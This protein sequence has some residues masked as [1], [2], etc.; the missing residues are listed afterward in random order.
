MISTVV[1]F[2]A[3]AKTRSGRLPKLSST[4][5]SSSSSVSSVALKLIVFLVSVAWNVT[6]A[7]TE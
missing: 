1:A 6:L 2:G 4:L 7:G 5:S 3:P